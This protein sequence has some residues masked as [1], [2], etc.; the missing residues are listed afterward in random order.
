MPPKLQVHL[1]RCMWG[2][3]R[4]AGGALTIP[5]AMAAVSKMGIY[6]GIELPFKTILVMNARSALRRAAYSIFP[7]GFIPIAAS[8][9]HTA[10]WW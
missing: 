4:E 7:D 8:S 3:I 5:D 9:P 10:L 1:Y 2:V 6:K